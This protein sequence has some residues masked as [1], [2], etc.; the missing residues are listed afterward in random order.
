MTDKL[1]EEMRGWDTMEFYNV[2]KVANGWADKAEALEQRV[3]GLEEG[4]K[5]ARRLLGKVVPHDKDDMIRWAVKSGDAV[6][7]NA[8]A[9][10]RTIGRALA[11]RE[12]E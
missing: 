11:S 5:E 6:Y 3:E 2:R 9:A 8:G 12:E 7:T 1:S 10:F 4:A